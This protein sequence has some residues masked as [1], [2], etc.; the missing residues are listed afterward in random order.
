VQRAEL[1]SY[2][3]AFVTIVLA[4]AM[5]DMI[6]STHRLIRSRAQ[7]KWDALPLVFAAIV[8]L[9]VITEFFALWTRFN[10]AEVTMLRLLWLLATPTL[11]TLLAYSVLPDDVPSEGVDLTA[12][13]WSQ[14]RVW[15]VMYAAAALLDLARSLEPVVFRGEAFARS[16]WVPALFTVA[17]LV[18][19]ALM[20]FSNSRRANW[21]GVLWLVPFVALATVDWSI[22]V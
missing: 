15:A 1:F 9:F 8:A 6:Q 17:M 19:P 3:S 13:Y 18:G 11:F 20:F 22:K 2:L 12:F 10:V 21:L 5:T 4:I 14:R 7:I 16:E